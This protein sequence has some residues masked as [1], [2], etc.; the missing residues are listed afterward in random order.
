MKTNSALR[1]G[2]GTD[3]KFPVD[4]GSPARQK[5]EFTIGKPSISGLSRS[6]AYGKCGGLSS[7]PAFAD[8]RNG[9]LDDDG[10]GG[11]SR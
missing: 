8:P 4:G 11:C 6:I 2:G 5:R 7:R 3:T 9:I 10:G 1:F